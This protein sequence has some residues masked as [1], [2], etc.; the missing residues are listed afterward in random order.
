M[1]VNR[2]DLPSILKDNEDI[3]IQNIKCCIDHSDPAAT[4][5]IRKSSSDLIFHILP[6]IEEFRQGIINNLLVIHRNFGI[7]IIFSKS[8]AVSKT[9]SFHVTL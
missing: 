1:I 7:K 8:L 2:S 3:F 6:S 9:I 4:V 5:D